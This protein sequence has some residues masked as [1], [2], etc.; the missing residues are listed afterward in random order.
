MIG[1]G[2][3]CLLF[4]KDMYKCSCKRYRENNRKKIFSFKIEIGGFYVLV[5]VTF[6]SRPKRSFVVKDRI[7]H[8]IKLHHDFQRNW[9]DI[10][11]D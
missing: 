11:I 2:E 5:M 1:L 10:G 8:F 3:Y 9:K 4:I 6:I 7:R